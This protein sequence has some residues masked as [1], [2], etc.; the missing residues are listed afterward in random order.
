M[1]TEGNSSLPRLIGIQES[2]SENE[3]EEKEKQEAKESPRGED[4]EKNIEQKT[5]LQSKIQSRIT[6]LMK[7]DIADESSDSES[8]ISDLSVENAGE[9]QHDKTI[10]ELG[11]GAAKKQQIFAEHEFKN[12]KDEAFLHINSRDLGLTQRKKELIDG[13]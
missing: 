8:Q 1:S 11:S 4:Y 10:K 3:E 6:R 13:D 9:Y 5:S 2:D 7:R 12:V